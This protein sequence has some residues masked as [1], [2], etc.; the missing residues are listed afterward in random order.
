MYKKSI[1]IILTVF[2]LALFFSPLKMFCQWER[3]KTIPP[4]YDNNY[5]LEIWF[6]PSDP[7]YIWI[8]GYNSQVIRTTDGG[9][10][11]AGVTLP[12]NMQLEGIMFPDKRVGYVSGILDDQ[13]GV[14][15]KSTDGGASFFNV[16]PPQLNGNILWGNYFIS[17]DTGMVMASD[18]GIQEFWRTTNGGARWSM[19]QK[20][21]EINSA[22]TDVE[23]HRTDTSWAV[24]SG[25]IW[26]STNIGLTW[27][28]FSVS[29]GDD[30]QEDFHIVNNTILVPY[31]TECA[32]SGYDGGMRMSTDRGNTWRQKSTGY[33]M[34]GTYLMD[35]KR[36]WG[37]GFTKSVYYTSDGGFNW[38]LRNC[39]IE[40]L[41]SLDDMCFINDTTGYVVGH[42]VYK[43]VQ[44]KTV[45][46]TIIT[47]NNI[48]CDG[49]TVILEIKE[50]YKFY[51]WSNGSTDSKIYV[52]KPGLYTAIA[53][54]RVCDT[55]IEDSINIYFNPKPELTLSPERNPVIC[56]GDTIIIAAVSNDVSYLWSTG[57]TTAQIKVTKDGIYRVKVTNIFGCSVADSFKVKV[58]PL[59]KPKIN[60]RGRYIFCIGDTTFLDVPS[61]FK[62]YKWFN[63]NMELQGAITNKIT[64][65]QSGTYSVI[66]ETKEGC[67]GNSDTV[68]IFV[69]IDK[70]RLTYKL[71]AKNNFSLDSTYYPGLI[72]KDFVIYN[73][74]DSI[75]TIDKPYLFGNL[76]F[77]I[78]QSQLSIKINPN[79][80]AVLKICFSPVKLGIER[81]TLMLDDVCDPHYVPLVALSLADEFVSSGICAGEIDA[82]TIA[83]PDKYIFSASE[84]YPNP[85]LLI[86]TVPFVK[87]TNVN[88]TYIESANLYNSLGEVIKSGAT[89]YLIEDKND[90]SIQ[91]SG[92]FIFNTSDISQGLYYIAI[93]TKNKRLIFPVIVSK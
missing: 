22:L 28:I 91:S 82:K 55:T 21:T 83:L 67:I 73:I 65:T 45:K 85:A 33:P 19:V 13:Y 10:S 63:K 7:N 42:G 38:E 54:D 86:I 87:E 90:N 32:G 72:C 40:G 46:P 59:P 51:K 84:P 71:A 64:V 1:N 2:L 48:A 66:V 15:Y 27:K 23:L 11:W 43:Y 74:S 80:S 69:K 92:E 68:N 4:P 24:S 60:V 39:G 77:S 78:P 3:I 25:R 93:R 20:S 26:I 30:W 57:D 81:D 9:K 49:D 35:E 62:S 41:D 29:G 58:V 70:N 44:T 12:G 17:R 18:C 14:I 52:T 47:S 5:W 75:Y 37:C 50:R 6:M 56:E 88:E 34:Y 8:C 31:N 76:A 89:G 16:T 61:G 53:Y 36:G 79:D